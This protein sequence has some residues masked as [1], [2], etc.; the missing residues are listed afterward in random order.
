M[1]ESAAIFWPKDFRKRL[2]NSF[3]KALRSAAIFPDQPRR[4]LAPDRA[5]IEKEGFRWVILRRSLLEAEV[6]RLRDVL[7][8]DIDTA[9]RL[10]E[11]M[12]A[13]SDVI[14]E[15]PVGV[16]GDAV[17]WDLQQRFVAPAESTPTP[18]HLADMAW[19][20]DG[21]P[22]YERKL[23]DFGRTGNVRSRTEASV[24]K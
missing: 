1:G 9:V 2:D 6:R 22:E 24:P 12:A 14:G 5:S 16:D 4:A 11:V 7:H 8:Q 21:M 19:E 18:A 20:E 10:Q 13:I 15:P 23:L 17:L 3:I